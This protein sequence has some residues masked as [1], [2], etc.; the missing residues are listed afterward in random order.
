[1]SKVTLDLD[2]H[3]AWGYWSNSFRQDPSHPWKWENLGVYKPIKL[4]I[5]L[6]SCLKIFGYVPPFTFQ[7]DM[8]LTS[9][10]LISAPMPATATLPWALF[11]IWYTEQ[12]NLVCTESSSSEVLYCTAAGLPILPS[13]NATMKTCIQAKW[14]QQLTHRTLF[15]VLLRGY[16][17]VRGRR[18]VCGRRKWTVFRCFRIRLLCTPWRTAFFA[19]SALSR[20]LPGT[21][22]L[23]LPPSCTFVFTGLGVM[24]F[25]AAA[26][27]ASFP[28]DLDGS[29]PFAAAGSLALG[30]SFDTSLG[31]DA[32][33]SPALSSKTQ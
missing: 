14:T 6:L 20:A 29:F 3:V 23:A 4:T 30:A 2:T 9:V 7:T 5:K 21:P 26:F 28:F 15:G 8:L 27:G 25:T 22:D 19:F 1:M 12:D 24:G 11:E 31:F 18:S 10:V 32:F 17:G 13:T 33:A 16:F